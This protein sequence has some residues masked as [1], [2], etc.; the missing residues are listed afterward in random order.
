VRSV[1]RSGESNPGRE[2]LPTLAKNAPETQTAMHA[3]TA[4]DGKAAKRSVKRL[5]YKVRPHTTRRNFPGRKYRILTHGWG[6]PPGRLL[7]RGSRLFTF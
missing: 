1:E 2:K 3:K 5:N 7:G 4:M 6:P